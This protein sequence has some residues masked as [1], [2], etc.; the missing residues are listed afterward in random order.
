MHQVIFYYYLNSAV[1]SSTHIRYRIMSYPCVVVVFTDTNGSSHLLY[2]EMSDLVCPAEIWLSSAP[3]DPPR[4]RDYATAKPPAKAG[5][6]PSNSAS[7]GLLPG[8][9]FS[10]P[11]IEGVTNIFGGVSL[12]GMFGVLL[13]WVLF[14][15]KV[16]FYADRTLPPWD[17]PLL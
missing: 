3:A 7:V 15:G 1:S 4:P 13:F 2:F 10:F 14:V 12:P 11:M 5:V 8:T 16:H 6:P 9:A 17:L